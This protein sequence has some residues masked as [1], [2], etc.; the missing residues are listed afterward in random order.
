[1]VLSV[2]L[3]CNYVSIVCFLTEKR[4]MLGFQREKTPTFLIFILHFL[5]NPGLEI[6]EDAS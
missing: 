4:K 2:C 1:M 5:P 6:G 3:F